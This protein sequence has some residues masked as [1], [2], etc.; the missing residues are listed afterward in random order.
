M[1]LAPC[2]G[3]C[4]YCLES[5]NALCYHSGYDNHH[6]EEIYPEC[7]RMANLIIT[8]SKEIND[9]LRTHMIMVILHSAYKK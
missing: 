6:K 7:V 2:F 3:K 4:H 1:Y 9:V 5:G 8:Y